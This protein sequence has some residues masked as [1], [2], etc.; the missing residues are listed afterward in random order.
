MVYTQ[1]SIVLGLQ[2]EKNGTHKKCMNDL[3]MDFGETQILYRHIYTYGLTGVLSKT[4]ES[5]SFQSLSLI[6]A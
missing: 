5:F 4:N 2:A 3:C 1:R 6:G